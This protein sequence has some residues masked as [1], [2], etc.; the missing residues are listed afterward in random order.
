MKEFEELSAR[1]A[2]LEVRKKEL[3]QKIKDNW[4]LSERLRISFRKRN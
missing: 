4:E 3:A 2:E 1:L